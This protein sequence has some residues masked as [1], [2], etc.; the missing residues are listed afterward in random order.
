[1]ENPERKF[2]FSCLSCG[3]SLLTG[4]NQKSITTAD[5]EEEAVACDSA[6]QAQKMISW[7]M[8]EVVLERV[9]AFMCFEQKLFP[10]FNA[11]SHANSPLEEQMLSVFFE[12]AVC[13]DVPARE[14]SFWLSGGIFVR[15]LLSRSRERRLT[16]F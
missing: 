13:C 1:M 15:I 11:I 12:R 4:A 7:K 14:G 5:K 6:L 2:D 3:G 10:K 8:L 16:A 9:A